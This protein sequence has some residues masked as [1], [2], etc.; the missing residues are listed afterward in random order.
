MGAVG[1]KRSGYL[2]SLDGWRALAILGVIM[3][4][5]LPWVIAGHSDLAFKDYGG[6]GVQLF[7]A[8]SGVL[9]CTRI[10]EEERELGE[11]RIGAF[12]VRRL[13]RIQPAAFCYL[14]VIACLRLAG[15]I[16]EQWHY[17]LGAAFLYQNYLFHALRPAEISAGFFTGHFW[18]LAVEEHFYI[19]LSL[20]LFFVRRRRAAA[21]VGVIAALLLLQKL[22]TSH[23][24][25]SDDVSNR[26]T[27]WQLQFL[28]IPALFAILLQRLRV[29]RA[30]DRFLHPWV[31]Y[32]GTFLLMALNHVR[33]HP[34]GTPFWS[35]H[36]VPAES[37]ALFV[38]FSLW[39]I[40]S[41]TH[42]GSWTTRVLELKPL[43]L[44]GR[45]SY[46]VYLW[47]V[48]FFVGMAPLPVTSWPPLL[49]LSE[50]PYKYLAA[51]GMALLSYYVV[52]KPMIRLG[53]R[54]APPATPGHRDLGPSVAGRPDGAAPAL[55]AS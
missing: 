9:I 55:Q 25:F 8:I 43:R 21:L 2:P 11:F 49:L 30:V 5:D 1:S 33:H 37:A 17:W 41:M 54:L 14:F 10:L 15:V 46:S 26:R 47:H 6:W 42:A 48:L 22:A 24:Y 36:F 23:G 32:V 38:G 4:H 35:A 27:F 7:F 18:T 28:L 40:A 29:R 12:Y 13:F 52:E 20:F 50:R 34:R 3:T 53:H 44:L 39:I 19:L 16:H 31:A 45:L 51:L